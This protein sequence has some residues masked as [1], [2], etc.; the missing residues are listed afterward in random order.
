[1]QIKIKDVEPGEDFVYCGNRCTRL[2]IDEWHIK[3]HKLKDE[4]Y[5][6]VYDH[7]F[8]HVNGIGM[9]NIVTVD[10]KSLCVSDL[11]PGTRF[12]LINF[13]ESGVFTKGKHY[14]W[15]HKFNKSHCTR[16]DLEVT[17]ED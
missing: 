10:R 16:G 8:K 3:E 5:I 11:K 4:T 17:L 1:M 9:E 6:Y 12:K 14:N 7:Y 2:K 15:Q 13:P